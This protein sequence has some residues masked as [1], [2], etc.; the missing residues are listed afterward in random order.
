MMVMAAK[1]AE[2]IPF[3]GGLVPVE[4]R[5]VFMAKWLGVG[6]WELLA[7]PDWLAAVEVC[8]AAENMS[9]PKSQ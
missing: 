9:R 8:C 7:H 2:F 4:Y 6:P 5:Y 1:G 3:A